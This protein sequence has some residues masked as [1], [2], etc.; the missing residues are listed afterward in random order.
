[1]LENG[2]GMSTC[3]DG[4]GLTS[5]RGVT[6]SGDGLN[7]YVASDNGNAIAV[8]SRDLGTGVVHQLPGTSGCISKTGNGGECDM[9][10]LLTAP[11][12]V[13][14]SP[15]GHYAYA[16]VGG[17]AG[18]VVGFARDLA[19]GALTPIAGTG[20]CV[21]ADGSG[22]ACATGVQ[23]AS[24]NGLQ[25]SPDGRSL[26]LASIDPTNA[27]TTF[28]RDPTTGNLSQL[29]GS[30]GCASETGSAGA[31]SAPPAFHALTTVAISPDGRNVYTHADGASAIHS[32]ARELPPTC[33]PVSH[34]VPFGA[35]TAI[36]LTCSDPNGDPITRT[37]V[38]GPS[39]GKLA[40]PNPNG[41]VLYTPRVRFGG[42][43]SFAF[44]ASDGTLS[45]G[46]A[47]AGLSVT[48]DTIR[49][50]ISSAAVSPRTFAVGASAA[51]L[52][53]TTTFRY[54]L[55][56][57]ARM[58]IT[59]QRRRGKR[60]VKVGRL[61]QSGKPGANKLRFKGKIRRR[62]LKPGSYRAALAATDPAGNRSKQRRLGFRVVAAK[63]H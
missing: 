2:G 23:V 29:P 52:K 16:P 33:S 54:R 7:V 31:C 50:R 38:S 43:D 34:A 3:A 13:A 1:V 18:G 27:L 22:G 58:V 49:P 45:S 62:A 46:T 17:S 36:P 57:R 14:L 51:A 25:V 15:D 39:N 11:R 61:T 21:T 42:A 32:F 48:P 12:E 59:I 6:V 20:G 47:L 35:P 4:R 24:G 56:E 40:A 53:R 55:S 5:A 30:A 19:S 44:S 26:Y 60:F 63:R 41:S 28:D 9:L 37:I 8:F 10:A